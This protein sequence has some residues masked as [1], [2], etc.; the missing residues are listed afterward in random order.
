MFKSMP[1]KSSDITTTCDCCLVS[2]F[3][4]QLHMV[5]TGAVLCHAFFTV[6][7][8]LRISFRFVHSC[9]STITLSPCCG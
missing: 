7:L 6:A 5:R 2:K 1:M 8:I 4:S 9:V 3:S